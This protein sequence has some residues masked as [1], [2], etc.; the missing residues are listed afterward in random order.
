MLKQKVKLTINGWIMPNGVFICLKP[1]EHTNYL[2]KHK[3]S[4]LGLV[5]VSTTMAGAYIFFE[6]Y[7]DGEGITQPQIDT[8]FE[9]AKK[10]DRLNEYKHFIERH[11]K[12]G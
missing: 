4:E 6:D 8:L 2:I 3:L 1:L 11:S 7:Y 5:K 10:F 9:W 12:N